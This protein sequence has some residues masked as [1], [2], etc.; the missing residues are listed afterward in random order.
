MYQHIPQAPVKIFQVE[1]NA[2]A[3]TSLEELTLFSKSL[4]CHFVQAFVAATF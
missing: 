2:M 1:G 4:S 3:S